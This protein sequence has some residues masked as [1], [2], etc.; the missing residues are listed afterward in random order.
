MR[1]IS[2]TQ[3]KFAMVDDEDFDLL[4][5]YKWHILYCGKIGYTSYALTSIKEFKAQKKT[6]ISMHRLIMGCKKFDSKIID[7]KD[8]NG[9]NNQKHNL[10]VCNRSENGKNRK[11]KNNKKGKSKYLG[12][13]LRIRNRKYKTARGIKECTDTPVWQSQIRFNGKA[14]HLGNFKTEIDAAKAYNDAAL[15]Y[16]GKFSRLNLIT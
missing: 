5:Q 14:H 7:H 3:G 11:A 8:G 6:S 2:L 16:H 9:L 10:R 13:Y 1:L 4:N 15:K 12:V